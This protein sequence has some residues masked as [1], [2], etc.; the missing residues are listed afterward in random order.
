MAQVGYQPSYAQQQTKARRWQ[1]SRLERDERCA[2]SSSSVSPRLV[3]RAGL[4]PAGL[5]QGRTGIGYESIYRF[6][7]AQLGRTK[8]AAWRHYLPRAKVSAAGAAARAA[9]KLHR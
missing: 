9:R 8:D 4:R 5:R 3:A 2:V 1:G 6:I 7:Y